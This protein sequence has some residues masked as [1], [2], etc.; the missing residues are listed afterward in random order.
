MV[1]ILLANCHANPNYRSGHGWTPLTWASAKGHA[2]VVKILVHE[3]AD[4]SG[5]QAL[6]YASLLGQADI[7]RILLS[8]GYNTDS[9]LPGG[10]TLLECATIRGHA[11]VCEV[12]LS[13]AATPRP[14]FGILTLN[15]LVNRLEPQKAQVMAALYLCF[16]W[17][18]YPSL[19]TV[20][21]AGRVATQRKLRRE[22]R[23]MLAAL[24]P[25]LVSYRPLCAIVWAYGQS[26]PLDAVLASTLRP[27]N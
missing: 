1:E 8:E 10:F 9:L 16:H 13:H 26:T 11:R 7:V 22:Q 14:C 18:L 20:H 6:L 12:L 4:V 3:T 19:S 25:V 27:A 15:E 2:A 23:A 21:R 17:E 5:S 24:G